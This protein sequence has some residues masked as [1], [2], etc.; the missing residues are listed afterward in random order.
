MVNLPEIGIKVR[1]FMVKNFNA[2]YSLK[3]EV[4]LLLE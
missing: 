3:N 4:I 1:R 2:H